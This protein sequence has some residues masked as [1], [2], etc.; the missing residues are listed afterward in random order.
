MPVETNFRHFRPFLSHYRSGSVQHKKQKKK[1]AFPYK[2]RVC[3]QFVPGG[4]EGDRTPYLLNAIQVLWFLSS[5]FTRVCGKSDTNLI[6]VCI[7]LKQIAA[8][9]DVPP[10]VLLIYYFK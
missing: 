7:K 4:D 5:Y 9:S 1:T 6:P 10:A 2:S 8:E 3:G